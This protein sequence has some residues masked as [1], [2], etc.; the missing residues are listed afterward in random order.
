VEVLAIEQET[1]LVGHYRPLT[2]RAEFGLFDRETFNTV[3]VLLQIGINRLAY[4]RSI[5]VVASQTVVVVLVALVGDQ[6]VQDH[7][8][9]FVALAG[10]LD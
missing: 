3:G 2:R 8:G 6:C 9:A 4:Q 10:R 7:L 1:R 5:T